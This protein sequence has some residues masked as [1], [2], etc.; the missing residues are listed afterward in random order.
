MTWREEPLWRR[1]LRFFGPDVDADVDDELAHHLAL[2]E[3]DYVARGMTPA[4]ARAAARERFGDVDGVRR[5]LRG[6]GRRR[7]RRLTRVRALADLGRDVR[8][9]ARA[10]RREPGFTAAVVVTLALGIGATTAMFSAVDA[11]LLRPLPFVDSGRLVSLA[12]VDVPFHADGFPERPSPIPDLPAVA[13][14][15]GV[16]SDVAAYAAGGLNLS[17]AAAPER[18]RVGSVTEAFFTTLGVRP[19]AGRTFTPEE[20]RPGGAKVVILSDALA[21]QQFGGRAVGRTIR[22]DDA[23][24]QVVGVMPAGFG[25]PSASDLWIPLTVPMTFESFA[26]FRNYIPTQVIARLAPAVGADAAAGRLRVLWQ[27]LTGRMRTDYADAIRTPLAPLQQDLAADRRTALLVLLGATGLLLIIA[28]A[29]VANLLLARS[30]ARRREI[31]LRAAL[32]ASRGRLARQLIIE[33]L[34]L[35]LAGALGGVVVAA[36]GLGVVRALMPASL[37][38]LAPVTLDFRVLGFAIALAVLTGLA[39]G[40]WPALAASRADANETLKAAGTGATRHGAGRARRVLVAGELAVTLTLLA[41]AGLMLRSFRALIDTDPGFGPDHVATLELA[42]GGERAGRAELGTLEAVIQRLEA[43][44]GVAAAGA[45]NDLPL[46]GGGGISISVEPEGR[47]APPGSDRPFAR[48]LQA[49]QGYFA[50]MD[51]RLLEGRLMNASDDAKAPEVAVIS[52]TMAKTYWPGED[53]IGKRLVEPPISPTDTVTR[54]RTVI[55]VVSDVRER[56]LETAPTPQMYWPI[57]E[58]APRNAAVVVRGALPATDLLASLRRAVREV[59]ATQAVYNVRTMDAVLSSSLAPRRVNTTLITAFGALALLLALV[60]VYGV[61]SYSVAQ[62]TRELGIRAAL[63]ATRGDL[64]RMV[65]REGGVLAGA[66]IAIG[67]AGAWAS[68]RVLRSL[69]YGVSPTDPATFAAAAL[70]LGVLAVLATLVP[71]RRAARLNPVDVIRA[72]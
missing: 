61:V 6:M 58:F 54:Y 39:F 1:Y 41:G 15:H 2:R 18:V 7:L 72:E 48:Y 16:F 8:Y 20:G 14:L 62:R 37:S 47:V 34:L 3:A 27:R 13:A 51:I 63:G 46:R 57:Y 33:S 60:G 49:S 56:D 22:L 42:F 31:A 59:D 28:A 35:A 36:M 21:R 64:V 23:S 38:H 50:A 19:A 30:A 71:A 66:G 10:L 67:L 65:V 4:Q 17:G 70:A 29:N 5:T 43:V 52:Q 44:P 32:G 24:Y 9:A 53:A 26:P 45:I 12:S 40:T 25:F 69:L 55:G 11:A 68:A